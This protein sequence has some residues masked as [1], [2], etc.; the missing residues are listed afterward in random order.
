MVGGRVGLLVGSI[1]GCH[2]GHCLLGRLLH[3]WSSPCARRELL[4]NK[5]HHG[6]T[7]LNNWHGHGRPLAVGATG[8]LDCS[9]ICKWGICTLGGVVFTWWALLWELLLL[10]A[11]GGGGGGL[12]PRANGRMVLCIPAVKPP[13]ML[14]RLAFGLWVRL[15]LPHVAL[16]WVSSTL[17]LWVWQ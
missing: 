16:V 3:N 7:R 9:K 17:P 11:T 10:G 15:R 2:H 8:R 6:L 5:I 13:M 14:A 1:V 4:A 12:R